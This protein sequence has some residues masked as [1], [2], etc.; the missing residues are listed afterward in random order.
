MT[1]STCR[2]CAVRVQLDAL[3]HLVQRA[4]IH[5]TNGNDLEMAH[6]LL[7]EVVGLL[8]TVIAIKREL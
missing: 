7:D 2:D 6:K 3:E 1:T 5:I 4:L 8:P